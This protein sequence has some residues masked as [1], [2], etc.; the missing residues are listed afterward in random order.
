MSRLS[1]LQLVRHVKIPRS[2]VAPQR[3][4]RI[5]IATASGLQPRPC[6]TACGCGLGPPLQAASD[7]FKCPNWKHPPL[8][9]PPFLKPICYALHVVIDVATTV[10]PQVRLDV[11]EMACCDKNM[12]CR[13]LGMHL[14]KGCVGGD[15]LE[16]VPRD[17]ADKLSKPELENVLVRACDLREALNIQAGATVRE[18][19]V[20]HLLLPFFSSKSLILKRSLPLGASV[21]SKGGW[22]NDVQDSVGNSVRPKSVSSD[23]STSPGR[24]RSVRFVRLVSSNPSRPLCFVHF[25][26]KESEVT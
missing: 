3:V 24:F 5:C 8:P 12:A 4:R 15:I 10:R 21:C 1:H 25:A 13:Q 22:L 19:D 16:L 7:F 11:R 18:V 6:A 23:S 9:V 2:L 26:C 14:T 17:I 20:M